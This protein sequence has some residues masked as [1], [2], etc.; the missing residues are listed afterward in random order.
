MYNKV[1]LFKLNNIIGLTCVY[2]QD[3]P[4]HHTQDLEYTHHFPKFPMSLGN[5]FLIEIQCLFSPKS[6]IFNT[7][8]I[9]IPGEF[10]F[11]Y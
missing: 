5:P 11:R 10:F 1:P 6:S 9:K 7:I 3:P 8:P 4:H 2:T